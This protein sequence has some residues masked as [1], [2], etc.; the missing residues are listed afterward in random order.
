MIFYKKKLY[1]IFALF[2]VT[3]FISAYL[4]S[5]SY[6]P[7]KLIN[8]HYVKINIPFPPQQ[9]F[10][11]NNIILINTVLQKE[12]PIFVKATRYW[13]Y[14]Y[15]KTIMLADVIFLNTEINCNMKPKIK[16]GP[17]INRTNTLLI[18][19]NIPVVK[20]L[21]LDKYQINHDYNQNTVISITNF[22]YGEPFYLI[23]ILPIFLMVLLIIKRSK[24]Q[25]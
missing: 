15:F 25:T 8:T 7:R 5:I 17:A 9:V 18:S 10:N 2:I 14:R 16:F 21:N 12:I 20:E 13:D 23:F 6:S 19:H 4:K 11:E 22:F 1:I 24:I 3:T